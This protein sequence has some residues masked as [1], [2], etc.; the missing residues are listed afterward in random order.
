MESVCMRDHS[1]PC[2]KV[3]QRYRELL[4]VDDVS[5]KTH[6]DKEFEGF[7]KKDK[8]LVTQTPSSRDFDDLWK[9]VIE[10][11]TRISSPW[12]SLVKTARWVEC[13][14][15]QNVNDMSVQVFKIT[16]KHKDQYKFCYD[17][18]IAYLD[19]FEMYAN[20]RQ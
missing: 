12:T 14:E 19:N 8:F 10:S 2:S 6:L 20:F 17:A 16:S 4:L 3:V 1:V 11:G 7:H 18:A 5:G 13:L 9:M 15:S